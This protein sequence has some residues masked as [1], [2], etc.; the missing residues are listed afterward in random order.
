[1]RGWMGELAQTAL[2]DHGAQQATGRESTVIA[3]D[4]LSKWLKELEELI[5]CSKIRRG[6]ARCDDDGR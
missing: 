1:M 2:D 6:I 5:P 3:R 4:K